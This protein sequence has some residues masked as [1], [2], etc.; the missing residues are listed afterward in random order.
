VE[1][2]P[3]RIRYTAFSL[4]YNIGAGWFGGLAPVNALAIVTATG[5]IYAGL[6]FPL[7][8][9]ALAAVIF[10]FLWPDTEDRDINA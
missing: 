5:N 10:F 2:F 3:P 8:V 6:W 7:I 1:L 4:P 9:T